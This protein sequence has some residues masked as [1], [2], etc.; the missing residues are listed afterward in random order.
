MPGT[1]N[2]LMGLAVFVI[3]AIITVATF[4]AAPGGHFVVAYGA[5]LVGAV[6]FVIGGGQWLLYQSRGPEGKAAHHLKVDVRVVLRS[7]IAMTAADEKL[8]EGEVAIIRLVSQAC[9]G[10]PL[11]KEAIEECFQQ[12]KGDLTAFEDELNRIG[13]QVTEE[14]AFTALKAAC[15][16]AM[17]DGE[18]H[19]S[20]IQAVRK[21]AG[22]LRVGGDKLEDCVSSARAAI[23]ELL[24][25]QEQQR[26]AP[27]GN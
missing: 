17:A 5:I 9:F 3:G 11:D 27:A 15:M 14:G 10:Q 4:A 21:L 13:G 8:D 19:Q 24:H 12:M 2:M 25:A 1:Y 7:M 26:A 18:V 23:N 16:V 22:A 6:Q 20:E